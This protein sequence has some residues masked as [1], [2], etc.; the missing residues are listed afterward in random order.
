MQLCPYTIN[1][2]FN[3][4]SLVQVRFK[5]QKNW[6]QFQTFILKD[7]IFSKQSDKVFTMRYRLGHQRSNSKVIHVD[8]QLYV[9]SLRKFEI[10]AQKYCTVVHFQNK[11]LSV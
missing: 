7:E 2:F 3:F 11:L 10:S 9:I 8:F 6:K 1:F 4:K 5:V